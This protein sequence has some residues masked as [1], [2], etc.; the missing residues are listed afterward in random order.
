MSSRYEA[1]RR[2]WNGVFANLPPFDPNDPLEHPDLESAL[3]WVSKGAHSVVDFGC[4]SGRALLRSL[5]LGADGGVGIDISD[6]AISLAEKVAR[7]SKLE[8]RAM[9]RRGDIALL[10]SLATGSFDSGILFN[11]VDSLFPEDAITVLNEYRRVVR[12]DGKILLKLNG[13]V[14]P[15]VLEGEYGAVQLTGRLYREK[16]GLYFWDLDDGEARALLTRLFTLE[17]SSLARL[18]ESGASNHVYYLRRRQ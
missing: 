8:G 3:R 4:G 11:I 16:T 17:E 9:F 7:A 10:S 5:V 2:H 14:E 15:A 18:G 12:P 13:F 6:S 1:S